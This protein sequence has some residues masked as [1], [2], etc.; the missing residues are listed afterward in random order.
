M[1]FSYSQISQYLRCPRGYRH[2]YLDGWREKDTRAA[3][4]FGRCFEKSLEAYFLGADSTVMFS[5]EWGAYRDAALEYS[6]G[7]DWARL[8]RQGIQ[9]LER[10]A[11]DDRVRIRQP[12]KN[13]QV[14]LARTLPSGDEFVSYIDAIGELDGTPCLIDWKTT[15][16]RYPEGPDGLLS[17]DPQLICYSWMS[18][19]S[20]V[21]LVVFLRKKFCEIQYL[22]AT[23]S[24]EQRREFGELVEATVSRISGGDFLPHSGIRFPQNGCVTCP[25][26]GLCLGS[27]PLTEAK[28]VRQ[29]GASE[30]DWVGVFD[31]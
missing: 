3:L 22:R 19:I 1:I 18:G 9:L 23:I 21:A 10:L 8:Y 24:E 4:L 14:K 30:L 5:E 29:P 11:Q 6:S 27:A 25:Y 15:T 16:S 31:E 26:V 28:L 17:L 2:R 7:D 12:R 20:D 13:L